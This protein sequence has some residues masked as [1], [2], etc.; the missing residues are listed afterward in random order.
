[1][2]KKLYRI[3]KGHWVGGVLN[4]IGQY[5]GIDTNILR[6]IILILFILP[7]FGGYLGWIYLAAWLLIPDEDGNNSFN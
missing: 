3:K 7:P 4:G 6:I 1:M 2:K 5:F